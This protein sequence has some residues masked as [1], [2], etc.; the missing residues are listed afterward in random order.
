LR[1][2]TQALYIEGFVE[3]LD[4]DRLD[5][6]LTNLKTELVNQN[7]QVSLLYNFLKFEMGYPMDQEIIAVD[8][9][10]DLFELATD[11][12]LSASFDY[13]LKPEYRVLKL[14]VQLN[15]LNVTLQKSS[16]YPSLSG[17]ASFQG[18]AQGDDIINHPVWS[19]SSFLGLSL[20]VPIFNGLQIKAKTSRARLD[21]ANVINQQIELERAITLEVENARTNYLSAI[22]SWQNQKKNVELAE[23]I[24]ETT[25]IKYREGVGSSIEITQAEQSLFNSQSNYISSRYDLLVA[26]KAL[27]KALGK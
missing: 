17:F 3:Q 13:E 25:Q 9:M 15:E 14:G 2:E 10:E 23:R 16:Y 8:G 12:E 20:K 11:E 24:Y 22:E 26:K 7:R 5:L 4:V 1:K 6:T 21:L 19:N 27:D 18:I